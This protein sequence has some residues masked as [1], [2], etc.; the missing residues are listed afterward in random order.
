V[1]YGLIPH[2]D[3]NH[4]FWQKVR[5]RVEAVTMRPAYLCT[6]EEWLA[7]VDYVLEL[8][9]VN[10]PK[11]PVCPHCGDVAPYGDEHWMWISA[12][13]DSKWHAFWCQI[14]KK[15]ERRESE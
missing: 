11:A 10:A 3:L 6:D 1:D 2:G 14:K 13:L 9:G 12:H 8:E 7:A 15:L 5:D 4:P